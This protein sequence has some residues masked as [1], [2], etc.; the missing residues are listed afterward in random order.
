MDGSSAAASIIAVVQLTESVISYL[1][2]VKDA[3][4]QCNNCMIEM[5]NL[6]TLLLR[7][8]AHL[9]E[10]NPPKYSFSSHSYLIYFWVFTI[11]KYLF[12]VDVCRFINL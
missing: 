11:V 9:A 4:K 2:D 10:L 1:N 7:L 3:P 5:S 12:L 8:N 6:N